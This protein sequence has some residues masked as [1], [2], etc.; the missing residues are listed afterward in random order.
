MREFLDG[1]VHERSK[2]VDNGDPVAA[3]ATQLATRVAAASLVAPAAV[4]DGGGPLP[5][6]GGHRRRDDEE[7][8][9]RAAQRRRRVAAVETR[10]RATALATG[11]GPLSSADLTATLLRPRRQR[12]CPARHASPPRLAIQTRSVRHTGQRQAVFVSLG[13]FH[14]A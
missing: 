4:R 5:T 2:L 12:R 14:C 6:G 7:I 9:R 13:P 3:V 10:P 11:T 1:R 8:G